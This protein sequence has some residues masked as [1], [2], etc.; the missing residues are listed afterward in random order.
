MFVAIADEEG[1][2]VAGSHQWELPN[3]EFDGYWESLIFDSHLKDDVSIETG[4][5]DRENTKY[6]LINGQ[7]RSGIFMATV[8]MAW[9]DRCYH[10]R[11]VDCRWNLWDV[12]CSS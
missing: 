3:S 1:E 2:T 5:I 7:S 8:K 9:S 4:G 12:H 6:I 10:I 11:R